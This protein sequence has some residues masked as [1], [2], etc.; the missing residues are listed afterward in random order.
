VSAPLP[1]NDALEID[2]IQMNTGLLGTC[3]HV[4]YQ[5]PPP[6][7]KQEGSVYE[8]YECLHRKYGS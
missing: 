5:H 6:W 2:Q 3:V 1:P 7:C 4:G 8:G